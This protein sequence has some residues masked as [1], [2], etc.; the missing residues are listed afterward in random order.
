M[1]AQLNSC[2]GTRLE[3]SLQNGKLSWHFPELMSY[4]CNIPGAKDMVFMWHGKGRYHFCVRRTISY[5]DLV[6][7]RKGPNRLQSAITKTQKRRKVKKWLLGLWGKRVKRRAD[8]RPWRNRQAYCPSSWQ[9][10]LCLRRT[11]AE[12]LVWWWKILIQHLRLNHAITSTSKCPNFWRTFSFLFCRPRTLWSHPIGPPGK[13]KHLSLLG[14]LLLK[15]FNS[16]LANI[17]KKYALPG[18]HVSFAK[19]EK[20]AHHNCR[21]AMIKLRVMLQRK[22]YY[23]ATIAFQYISLFADESLRFDRC[24][25]LNRINVQY[26]DIVNKV[27]LEHGNEILLEGG[28]IGL[29]CEMEKFTLA[30]ERMFASHCPLGLY[31]LKY[32]PLHLIIKDLERV[33]I[34]SFTESRLS[35]H[36]DV[37]NK[38]PYRMVSQRLSTWVQEI[39]QKLDHTVQNV[40]KAGDRKRRLGAERQWEGK[41]IVRKKRDIWCETER[42]FQKALWGPTKS[43]E[44]ELSTGNSY[45][46]VL[47]ELV[48]EEAWRLLAKCRREW[49]L[50]V[51]SHVWRG[52]PPE[53]CR[54]LIYKWRLLLYFERLQQ[55][56]EQSR[57]FADWRF[58]HAWAE[59]VPRSWSQCWRKK[60]ISS[61]VEGGDGDEEEETWMARE[62][63][64]YRRYL[65][66]DTEGK[67]LTLVQYMECV[68]PVR[69]RMRH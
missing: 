30:V 38:H 2:S 53:I 49:V 13:Q 18:L 58:R 16:I 15:A 62:L 63:Y 10:G 39:L 36:L 6:Q 33:G 21:L 59:S 64:L 29:R 52:C 28:L 47:A 61:L 35:E 44:T 26:S 9:G 20:T 8:A 27:L 43:R 11:C 22:V 7:S 50:V 32:H 4:C 48:R 56:C 69:A 66:V 40:W 12:R 25:K 17:E 67:E 23:A 54:V 37:L 46:R 31:S 5:E 1:L 68:P 55:C 24:C 19:R 57:D 45:G 42:A 65:R 51:R 41:C 34:I 60:N 14:T 3:V